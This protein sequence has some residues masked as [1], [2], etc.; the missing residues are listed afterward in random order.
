MYWLEIVLFIVGG[1]TKAGIYVKNSVFTGLLRQL[2]SSPTRLFR[3]HA[4]QTHSKIATIVSFAQGRTA[5][6]ELWMAE[7][8][9]CCVCARLNLTLPLH[10]T[11]FRCHAVQR[12]SDMRMSLEPPHSPSLTYLVHHALCQIVRV[13]VKDPDRYRGLSLSREQNRIV[14]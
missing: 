14:F 9:I 6:P 13:L 8:D 12:F 10:S 2:F 7:G 11:R 3:F 5:A 4:V 1:R